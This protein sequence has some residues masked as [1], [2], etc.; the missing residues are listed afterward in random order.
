MMTCLVCVCVYMFVVY[1]YRCIVYVRVVVGGKR[2]L[3]VKRTKRNKTT[4]YTQ[5]ERLVVVVV[6]VVVVVISFGFGVFV[7]VVV[8]AVT[9]RSVA[10]SVMSE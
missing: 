5:G 1:A 9:H 10:G 2:P 7:V 4:N 8:G 6:V 3:R